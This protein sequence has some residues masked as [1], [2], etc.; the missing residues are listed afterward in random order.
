VQA[1]PRHSNKRFEEFLKAEGIK[2]RLTVPHTPEQNGT[3][4]RKNRTLIDMVRCM[5]LQ[6]GLSTGFW[7]EAVL[8]ANYLRNRCPTKSLNGRTPF[9][10]WMDRLPN[11]KHLRTFG[12][13]TYILNKDPRKKK[14]DSRSK[15]DI[16]I[17]YSDRVKAYRV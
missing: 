17:G 16:F 1:R 15:T 14:F 10:I 9:E 2:R 11:L 13:R 5:L 7:A 8:T 12:M 4:E 3:T 6:A